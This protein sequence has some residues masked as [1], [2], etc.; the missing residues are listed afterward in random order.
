MS[1]AGPASTARRGVV[2]VV[3]DVIDDVVVRPLG[4]VTHDSD[5]RA[6]IVRREGGSG[7]NT[8]CWMAWAGAP[9]TFVGR[10]AA[11]DVERHAAA[12]AA[13]G[14]DARLVADADRETGRIIIL[15]DP[16]GARTM[17]T[18]RGANLALTAED[19][20]P[21]LVED[22]ALVHLSG[23]SFVEPGVREAALAVLARA[24]AAGVPVS[25]DP[26]SAAFLR[27]VG[28]AEFLAWTAGADLCLPNLDEAR[29]LTGV[30]DAEDAA[31]ALSSSYGMVVVTC[32]AAGAVVAA[33]GRVLGTVAEEPVAAVDSTGA[34]DSFGAGFLAAWT[35]GEHD[36]LA[37]AHAGARLARGAV[38]R[39]GARPPLPDPAPAA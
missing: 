19:V 7:A 31:V 1:G 23:Y 25:V 29:V 21:G 8:A 14:V 2:V 35:S 16:D 27:E 4:P 6:V 22:A 10:V 13:F 26:N 30:A 3:G 34:G 32:G 37:A 17:F 12:M 11:A 28:P 36:P 20:P 38:G 39:M 9:V 33:G 24:R 5:T 18:D 15:V